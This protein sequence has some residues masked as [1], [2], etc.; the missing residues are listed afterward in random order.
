M[1]KQAVLEISSKVLGL[2]CIV[3]FFQ[4]TPAIIAAIIG[5]NREFISNQTL[6]IVKTSL[7]P[8]VFLTLAYI[9]LTKS[10]TISEIIG[11]K[12]G[13]VV[14][15]ESTYLDN[16]A[17]YTKLHFWILILGI[18][19]F[20]S[21]VATVL[22]GMVALSYKLKNGW[23]ILHDPVLPQAITLILSIFYIFR[24]EQ[25][26]NFLETKRN[27]RNKRL[28]ADADTSRR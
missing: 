5:Q 28:Q 14:P 10:E 7:Y 25:I 3:Q 12:K 19:F 13:K 1:P 23:F 2:Y 18:C 26:A 9:L 17:L 4:S 11:S 22:T 24:S 20:I 16:D 8:L 21:A 15:G 6:H 27:K